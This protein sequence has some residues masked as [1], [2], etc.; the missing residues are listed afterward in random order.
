MIDPKLKA[1]M[2]PW[3]AVSIWLGPVS[4]VPKKN[5]TTSTN[6]ANVHRIARGDYLR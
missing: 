6:P 5:M 1:K 2:Q 4:S 3:T